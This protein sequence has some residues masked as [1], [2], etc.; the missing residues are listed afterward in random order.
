[1]AVLLDQFVQTLS[2]SGLMTKQEVQQL[3]GGLSDDDKPKDG[4]EM[5][6]LLFRQ[7]KLTKFQTQTLYKGKAKGLILGDYVLL[8]QIGEGGMG[9]V[10]R[11]QHRRMKRIVALKVLP[12]DMTKSDQ[13]K[14]RFQ[15]E[16]EAAAR[17]VH[18]NI[19][20]A[21]DAGE[22]RNTHF[23]VMEYVDGQDL[24][25]V[26]AERGSLP[27]AEA[28]DYILQAAKGLE[29]AHGQGVIHRDIKPANLL[30]DN[31]GTVK[32]LDMGL[33]RVDTQTGDY[34]VTVDRGLTQTGEVMGTVDYMSPE[35]ATSTKEVDERTD[36]YSLGCTLF[37]LLAGQ[38]I[39]DGDTL[40]KRLLAH[41]EHPIPSLVKQRND[42]PKELDVAFRRM[43]NKKAEFRTRSMTEVIAQL[44]KVGVSGKGGGGKPAQAPR[45]TQK[46]QPPAHTIRAVSTPHQQTKSPAP[47]KSPAP[48]QPA[49]SASSAPPP[50]EITARD[51]T[52]VD[53]KRPTDREKSVERVRQLEK[54]KERA[55]VWHD[56]VDNALKA[57]ARKSQWEKVRRSLGDGFATITKWILLV[58]MV[59]GIPWGGF[60]V[61]QN[62]QRLV[63]SQERVL[64][65]VNEQLS[66]ASFE[67]ISAIDFVDTTYGWSVPPTLSF[68]RPLYSANSPGRRQGATLKGQ[69]DRVEGT[70][71]ILEPFQIEL[72]VE[73]VP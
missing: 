70:V 61:Y 19:V 59:V 31:N 6:K 43:V 5:A 65:A 12:A 17:L 62:A 15:Q 3:L 32:I 30:L 72:K 42:V 64:S 16:V 35:Q 26:V 39:Y 51:R 7:G 52:P 44:E 71:Q 53:R 9:Q 56:S 37:Y 67:S 45:V 28:L 47:A 49:K 22:T 25:D 63:H 23:L 10:F 54:R 13:A 73:P 50:P 2:D 27:L 60:L 41:R 57:E 66:R 36:I 34:D 33:A 18:T 11:A 55:K 14:D 20:T 40:V 46:T 8:D 38:P 58:V 68:E 24:A 21:F 29:Y 1:M 69:F 4:E 48:N